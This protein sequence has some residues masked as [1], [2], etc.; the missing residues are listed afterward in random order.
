MAKMASEKIVCD[1]LLAG[2]LSY[3]RQTYRFPQIPFHRLVMRGGGFRRGRFNGL[4]TFHPAVSLSPHI[5]PKK[6]K[7]NL[8]QPAKY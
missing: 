3:H 5:E 2:T 7:C 8:P 1:H 4:V 6:Q